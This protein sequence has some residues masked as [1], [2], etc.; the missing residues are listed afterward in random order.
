MQQKQRVGD[1]EEE[2]EL[3]KKQLRNTQTKVIEQSQEIGNLKATNDVYD[4]QIAM[5]TD[6]LLTTQ[7]YST[8]LSISN[9]LQFSFREN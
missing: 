2:L 7:V 3:L 9:N 4:T 5:F 6:E 1:L 8:A